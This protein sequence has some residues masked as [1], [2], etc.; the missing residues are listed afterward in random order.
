MTDAVRITTVTVTEDVSGGR[1][2]EV[3]RALLTTRSPW[4]GASGKAV[5]GARRSKDRAAPAAPAAALRRPEL[6]EAL[7]APC[8]AQGAQVC[9]PVIRP[10]STLLS[11][12][13]QPGI[14]I[15][16]YRCYGFNVTW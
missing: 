2:V 11:F 14:M 9:F 6:N 4:T 7:A 5:S 16:P 3:S 10:E 8:P 15:Q 1:L 12:S 13:I